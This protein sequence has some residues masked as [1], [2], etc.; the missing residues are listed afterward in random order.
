[1]SIA[2]R[3]AKCLSRSSTCA[4]HEAFGQRRS[5]SPSGRTASVPQTGQ[6]SGG[7]HGSVPGGRFSSTT[8]TTFGI[9]SPPRSIRTVSPRAHVLAGDLLLV[10]ERGAA[11]R[12][13]REEHRLE[14]RDRRQAG[15]CGPPA[16]RSPAPP[17][18][19]AAPGT[20]RRSPSAG[21]STS[22]RAPA[23]ARSRPPSRRRRRSRT[24]APRARSRQAS[25]AAS[26]SADARQRRALGVRAQAPGAQPLERLPLALE[27][28]PAQV[29]DRVQEHLEARASP[30]RGRRGSSSCRPR[31][32]SGWRTAPPRPPRARG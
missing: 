32:S 5:T 2:S 17:S 21:T 31:R 9:T 25:I 1:M 13:S 11:H 26:T 6:R 12:G 4:G 10:V 7:A 24:R 3:R 27:L 15:R 18:R 28:E 20:C 16:P 30:R 19:P 8:D 22:R 14:V 29:G 23:A